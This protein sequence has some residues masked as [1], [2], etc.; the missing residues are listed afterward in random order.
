M[1]AAIPL[2]QQGKRVAAEAVPK[3]AEAAAIAPLGE[4]LCCAG[5]GVLAVRV[6]ALQGEASKKRQCVIWLKM[7]VAGRRGQRV[8]VMRPG[9]EWK[10]K[11]VEGATRL[12]LEAHWAGQV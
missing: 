11:L 7:T 9:Q 3:V 10:W 2:A 1:P 8:E 6:V 5:R 4:T 12:E